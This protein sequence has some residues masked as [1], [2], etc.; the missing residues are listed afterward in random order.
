MLTILAMSCTGM[1]LAGENLL[2][3]P[4]FSLNLAS[5]AA[6]TASR[7]T[8][9]YH[10]APGGLLLPSVS[11]WKAVYQEVAVDPGKIYTASAWAKYVG[12]ASGNVAI[13]W[14]E[15]ATNKT[16][17]STTSIALLSSS[18]VDWTFFEV[19]KVVPPENATIGAFYVMITKNVAATNY[20][21]DVVF[22]EWIDPATFVVV[23]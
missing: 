7:S 1:L 11:Y 19:K 15:S 16:I 17:I 23:R 8:N 14:Y 10:S 13:R 6:G 4:S 3:N 12:A 18:V 20:V 2:K 5:W 21:D 22:E 9:V